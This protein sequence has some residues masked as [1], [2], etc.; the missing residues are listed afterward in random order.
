MRYLGIDGGGSK[1]A[2]L[3]VD[4]YYNE[5]CHVQSGPSNYLSVGPDAAREAIAQ[6]IAQLTEQPGI[7]C[8]G[9]AG[10]GRPDGVTFYKELLR[11]LIPGSQVI[12]ESDAFIASIG[13]IGIDPGV[14]LIAGT[15]SIVIGRD[16]DRSMF[17]VGG[18]GPYFGDE[19]SGFWIGREAIRAALRSVDAQAPD[20]FTQRVAVNL[21]LK[22]IS[23]IVGAWAT[24]KAGVPEVAGLFPEVVA[25]YPTEPAK[26]ILTDAAFH[27][28]S[29]VDV[30]SKRV[31]L[32]DCRRSLS[33]S[34]A[35]HP[36]MRELI[37]LTFEEPRQSPEWGAVIWARQ[38][39]N[40]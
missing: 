9:F 32:P 40:G 5:I 13:A 18:W 4:E 1:T 17:R 34:V 10:A 31:G 6:G 11:T 14:L 25:M 23:E 19:G 24:G 38:H 2:F 21:G 16:K 30:A 7:V 28:R 15:G 20:E 33:G 29:L 3:L 36:I 26:Q 37:G 27:L 35:S 12:N 39:F 8:A 22:S